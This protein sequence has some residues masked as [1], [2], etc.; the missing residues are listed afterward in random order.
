MTKKYTQIE[1]PVISHKL[2]FLRDAKT[3]SQEFRGIMNEMSR[4]IAYEATRDLKTCSI[5]IETP[6]AKTQVDRIEESPMLV[7]IM[8]AG[9]GMI[10]G[11]LSVL[12]FAS[13]GHIGIYR[14]KFIGNTVEYYFKLPEEPKGRT[15][16][17]LDPLVATGDTAVACLDR[18]KQYDVGKIKLLSILVSPQGL[19]KIHHFHPDVEIVAA[20]KEESLTEN[21]YLLPGIGDAGDRL[22]GIS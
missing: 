17:L 12:P 7:S 2:S 16:L 13:A 22:Y 5:D 19:E 9:N 8:R 21:G 4:L 14:D 10:D 6:L 11:I 20:A 1:H 15:V 3:G 18:L